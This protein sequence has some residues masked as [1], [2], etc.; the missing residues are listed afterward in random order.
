M[1]N[2]FYDVLIVGSGGSGLT[3]AIFAAQQGKKVAVISKVHPLKSHTVAAQGGI[4]AALGNMD[5]DDPRWHIYDTIKASDWLAD[6][7]SVATMCYGAQDIIKMLEEIGVEFDRGEDGKIDQKIYGGQTTNFGKG[8][9]AKRACYSKDKTGHTIMHCLYGEAKKYQVDFY[10]YHFTLDLIMHNGCCFGAVNLDLDNGEVIAIMAANTIIACGGYSQ[11]Y[12]TA[13]SAAIC[14]GDGNAL[15]ARCG[16]PLQ[17][18][19]FVQFHPTAIHKIG[20]LITEAARSAGAKLLNANGERFMQKYAPNFLELAPRDVVARAIATE[21]K[22]GRGAGL[23]K[24]SVFLDLT[25]LSRQEIQQNL[26]TV[27]E[28]CQ[29][30][31]KLDPSQES[32]PVS[33]AAHYTM[34]GIATDSKC[35]VIISNDKLGSNESSQDKAGS[36]GSGQAGNNDLT[37]HVRGLFAIGEAASISVHGANRLGCNSLLDLL[38]FARVAVDNLISQHLPDIIDKNSITKQAKARI[39]HIID[40]HDNNIKN[41]DVKNDL[42]DGV[43]Q[44]TNMLKNIMNR[45]ASVFRDQTSLQQGLIKLSEL[46]K[47]Y[48]LFKVQEQQLAWNLELIKYIELGNMMICGEA[49]I[50]S[51]L[52]RRESRGAHYRNDFTDHDGQFLFHSLI[53][54]AEA[55][56]AKKPVR[57]IK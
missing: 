8:G 43:G 35:R 13:T 39:S 18:M 21:I 44:M 19:E 20:V 47:Q 42:K 40:S 29:K 11:I 5:N 41:E 34:G 57:Q 36:E 48:S 27:F 12:S 31:L 23:E 56:I 55:K 46:K 7:D 53:W 24:D 10:N 4:N 22:Q 25:H 52:W 51:A 28:N 2:Q 49:T 50:K 9:F 1:N 15:V 38:V 45:H 26:P 17:D 14:T 30:F 16:L 54:L 32:I 6:E 33:P 3:A 37:D